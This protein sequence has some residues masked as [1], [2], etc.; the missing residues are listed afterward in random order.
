ML[1]SG[2]PREF[3][4]FSQKPVTRNGR[5][6]QARLGLLARQ[7]RWTPT[8]ITAT[9]ISRDFHF[10]PAVSDYASVPVG[11]QPISSLN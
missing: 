6:L 8:N 3:L 1:T 5:T 9:A 2:A 10:V 4:Q 7:R 11:K